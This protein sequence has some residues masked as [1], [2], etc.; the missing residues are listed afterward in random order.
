MDFSPSSDVDVLLVF[1]ALPTPL[2]IVNTWIDGRL[3]EIYCTTTEA[4]DRI[5]SANVPWS[6]ASEEATILGWLKE[7]RVYS[8][9]NGSLEEARTRAAKTPSPLLPGDSLI[10]EAWRK[11]GYNVAQIKRYMFAEDLVSQTAV[12]LRLLYSVDEV[13][14]H[15]FTVRGLPWRGEKPAIRYWTEKDPY[16]LDQL[17][18]FFGETDRFR[19]VELYETLARLTLSP[20]AHL[21]GFG[22]TAISLGA[23]Y[24]SGHVTNTDDPSRALDF[25]LELTR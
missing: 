15:Y 21:W 18:Q 2:R 22:E 25:W 10:H 11:I 8:D 14:F 19:R 6:D 16:F 7:G 3:A 23:G 1:S 4:I 17:R 24:G 9:R 13:K 20:I 5:V 12:D